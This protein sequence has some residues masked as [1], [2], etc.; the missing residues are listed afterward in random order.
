M[1]FTRNCLVPG[2]FPQQLSVL[3]ESARVKIVEVIEIGVEIED[4]FEKELTVIDE[5]RP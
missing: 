4:G 5:N 1:E 2:L 3:E